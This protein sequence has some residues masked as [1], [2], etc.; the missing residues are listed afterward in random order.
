MSEL[1]HYELERG[2]AGVVLDSP[3]NRNALSDQLV[4]ELDAALE[5]ARRDERV[6]GVRLTGTGTTFCSGADLKGASGHPARIAF[7][8]IL[9]TM[10]TYPKTVVI[11]LNGH[12]RAGGMGLL[13]AA[14]VVV[15]PDDATF[16]F[17]EVR[18]GVS[19]AIIAVVCVRRM[20]P[21]AASRY[22]L[23]GETFD[24]AAAREAGLVTTTVPRHEVP[25]ATAALLDA[26]RT[27]EPTAVRVT[28]DLLA[29]LPSLSLTDGLTAAA[30]ISTTLFN[31]EPAAEGI[32]ALRERRA[33]SWVL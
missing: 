15:A 1:V 27:A 19:P 8:H 29:T 5:E 17:A 31:S 9:E 20:S 28:K 10:W 21:R 18:I 26:V 13:A 16:G 24:A 23:T 12:V 4:S 6:R 3:D 30:A 33:P 14:D 7:S 11:E 2:I 22:M 32:A 25:A